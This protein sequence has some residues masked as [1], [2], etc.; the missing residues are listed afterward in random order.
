MK[1]HNQE[2][3]NDFLGDHHSMIR[4]F[5]KGLDYTDICMPIF[6]RPTLSIASLAPLLFL[7]I[8]SLGA[9]VSNEYGAR[10]TGQLIHSHVWQKTLIVDQLTKYRVLL[11]HV[12][13]YALSRSAHEKADVFHAMLVTLARRSSLLAKGFDG[14]NGPRQPLGKRWEAWAEQWPI[15]YLFMMSIIQY[16]LCIHNCYHLVPLP[17]SPALWQAKTAIEWERQ[18][19]KTR[20][21]SRASSLRSLKASVELLLQP[22]NDHTRQR[23]RGAL[24]HFDGNAL[25]LEILIHG[26]ASA[27]LEHRFRGVD[28][29]CAPGINKIKQVDFEEG[30][31]CWYSCFEHRSLEHNST[32]MSRMALITYHFVAILMRD[33]LSDIQMAAGTA[34]SWG[35]V[36]TPQRAQEAFLPLIST[37]PVRKE[38]YHHALK[39]IILSLAEEQDGWEKSQP[40]TQ[41]VAGRPIRPLHLT[42]NAFIAVLVLWSHALGLS[43]SQSTGNRQK[44]PESKVLVVHGGKLK[45]MEDALL[46]Q[47]REGVV[48]SNDSDVLMDIMRRG[49]TQTEPDIQKVE[50]IRADVRRLME[51]VR[52][53]LTGSKWEICKLAE[54]KMTFSMRTHMDPAQEARRVLEGLLD[55]N[56]FME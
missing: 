19:E 21:P 13:F 7:S 14:G 20:H 44:Q 52:N 30:L 5:D 41:P 27:V 53:R 48:V 49:F 4:L 1:I 28:S 31:A 15:P 56:G 33:S 24:Q 2:L 55:K 11:E 18:M 40:R 38:A 51:M 50:A 46:S 45:S 12:G 36:V 23:R 25:L 54:L 6:H 34:Y 10:E 9:H 16:T 29:G 32:E 43:R 42:Y 8:C 39:I 17:C 3:S 26:L 22:R 35:R 37:N 47:N